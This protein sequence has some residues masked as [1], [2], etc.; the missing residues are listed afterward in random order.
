MTKELK[1]PNGDYGS[2]LKDRIKMM[3]DW[4]DHLEESKEEAARQETTAQD[5]TDDADERL[6]KRY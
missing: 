5:L 6:A 4:A 1:L 2:M 3:Q